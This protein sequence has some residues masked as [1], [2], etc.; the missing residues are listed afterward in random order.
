MSFVETYLRLGW[1]SMRRLM[2]G[3]LDKLIVYAAALS[4]PDGH[5]V[6]A[7]LPARC[8]DNLDEGERVLEPLRKFGTPIA[9][10]VSR[11]PYPAMQQMIDGVAPFGLRSYWKSRFLQRRR[12]D[13]LARFVIS[14]N[15]DF[16]GTSQSDMP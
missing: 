7:L 10:M 4:T 9:D 5:P 3:L 2:S 1:R 13:V 14:Q 8:G 15:A 16:G 12:K 6:I 11:M